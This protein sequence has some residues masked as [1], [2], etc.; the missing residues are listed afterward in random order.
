MFSLASSGS[1]PSTAPQVTMII[2]VRMVGPY[3]CGDRRSRSHACRRERAGP[4]WPASAARLPGVVFSTPIMY[5]CDAALVK[6]T[7]GGPKNP[8]R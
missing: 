7:T 6:I 8:I 3:S 1:S 4:G 2:A 5:R